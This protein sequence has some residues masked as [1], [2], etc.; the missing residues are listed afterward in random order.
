MSKLRLAGLAAI[1]AILVANPGLLVAGDSFMD[2]GNCCNAFKDYC[3]FSI[4]ADRGGIMMTNCY[5][6]YCYETCWCW[7]YSVHEEPPGTFCQPCIE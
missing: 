5:G 6:F 3:E 1:L 4:C 7:D 2:P